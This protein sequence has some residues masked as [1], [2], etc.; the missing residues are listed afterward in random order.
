MH[1]D[2]CV[3]HSEYL[4]GNLSQKG[5]KKKGDFQLIFKSATNQMQN[6]RHSYKAY[7]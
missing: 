1:T 4:K 5:H 6:N 7:F 3:A 2:V